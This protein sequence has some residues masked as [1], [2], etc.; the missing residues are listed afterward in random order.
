[1]ENYED[2]LT[3]AYGVIKKTDLDS[4]ERFEIKRVEGHHEGTKTIITNFLQVALCLRREPSHLSKFLFKELATSGEISGDRLILTRKLPS[5]QINEKIEK[6]VNKFVL[7][8][9]CKKPDT[10]IIDEGGKSYLKCLACGHKY[11]IK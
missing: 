6:Y 1:M 7:C 11:Q 8:S 3:S 4:C 2:L 9:F 5:I 10:E